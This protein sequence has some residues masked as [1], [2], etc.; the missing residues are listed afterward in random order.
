[1]SST[2]PTTTGVLQRL[3]A[4]RQTLAE[5][6][7]MLRDTAGASPDIADLVD[8]GTLVVA[9]SESLAGVNMR[10]IDATRSRYRYQAQHS[11][12]P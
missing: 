2:D 12:L 1:V 5:A 7:Q 9:I 4:A 10:M 6:H 3:D 8:L 11:A